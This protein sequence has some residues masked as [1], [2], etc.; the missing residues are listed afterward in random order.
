MNASRRLAS[1]S[2]V[3]LQRMNRSAVSIERSGAV[4]DGKGADD[5]DS[6][7]DD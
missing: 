4:I 5:D 2:R 7:N 6:G 3:K 1:D